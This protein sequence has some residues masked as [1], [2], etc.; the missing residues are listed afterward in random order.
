MPCNITFIALLAN[1]L[2]LSVS[3]LQLGTFLNMALPHSGVDRTFECRSPTATLFRAQILDDI[4][5]VVGF[6]KT[7][8]P[9]SKSN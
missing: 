3:P 8:L 6:L 7:C 1:V 5:R 9:L 4:A 2:L